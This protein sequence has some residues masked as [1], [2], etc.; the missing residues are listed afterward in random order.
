[1]TREADQ[2]G[3]VLLLDGLLALQSTIITL[4]ARESLEQ[5]MIVTVLLLLLQ[6]HLSCQTR[7]SQ[8]PHLYIQLD[9]DPWALTEQTAHPP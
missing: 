8:S 4:Q 9:A 5:R 7:S 2:N 1:M 6:P 3:V